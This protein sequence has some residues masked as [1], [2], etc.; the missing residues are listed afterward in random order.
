MTTRALRKIARRLRL[1]V[2]LIRSGIRRNPFR[3]SGVARFGGL[4][5]R[6]NDPEVVYIEHKDIFGHKIYDFDTD[7]SDPRVLDCGAHL[8][9]TTLYIRQRYP[10]ARITAFEPDPETLPL[11]RANLADN[12]CADVEIVPAAL[13]VAEGSAVLVSAH[14]GS[15]LETASTEGVSVATVPLS[16]YL[17]E[18]VQFL[19][20]N[21]EG[22]ELGVLRAA[23]DALASVE[24][25][26]I[27][28][29]GFAGTHQYLHELL[30]LL[31]DAGFRYLVHDFDARTNPGTKPPFRLDDATTYFL[32]VYATRCDQ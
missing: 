13:S 10:H 6:F 5:V 2:Q 9:L 7:V 12:G 1:E 24:R 21:I 11:L 19:K 25:M 29:H 15:R 4:R 32:L 27:E 17:K 31:D 30:A 20:M 18:P 28:Y 26:V 16:T 3:T 23:R 14:D 22:A 8:G